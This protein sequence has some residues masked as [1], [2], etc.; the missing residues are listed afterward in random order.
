[1]LD[2]KISFIVSKLLAF[3]LAIK[4]LLIKIIFKNK[5][6]QFCIN[7]LGLAKVLE[8]FTSYF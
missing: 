8:A 6:I 3:I 4:K 1:M 5:V 2:L 7:T